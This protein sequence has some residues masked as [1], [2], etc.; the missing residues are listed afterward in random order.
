MSLKAPGIGRGLL[1]ILHKP[2]P[3]YVPCGIYDTWDA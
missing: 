3:F 2:L 1:H